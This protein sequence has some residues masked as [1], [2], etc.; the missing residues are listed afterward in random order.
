MAQNPLMRKLLLLLT[1]LAL[2]PNAAAAAD[3]PTYHGDNTRQGNDSS[4]PG[5]AA[6]VQIWTSSQVDGRVYGSPVIVAGQVIVATE[7]NTVYS[8]DPSTG[9][10]QWTQHVGTPRTHNFP[11]GNINP[12]GI[13]GTPVV[14]A[15]SV[16]VVAEIETAPTSFDFDLVTLSLATGAVART[17]NINPT[18]GFNANMQQQR[19]ALL[20]TNGRVFVPLGGLNGDCGSYHGYVVSYPETGSGTL[21]WF[22]AGG[23]TN[24]GGIWAAGGL[25]ADATGVY[26]STGNS[27]EFKASNAYDYSDGVI[28]LSTATT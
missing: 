12:L 5:L 7:N 20:V 4:D 19:G 21:Q 26:V 28:K 11:C 25:S 23:T 24:R 16:Y 15:G 17:V 18:T 13:T 1:L 3:W 9:A 2:V 22:T 27:D 6:P 14:D 10:V 8:L